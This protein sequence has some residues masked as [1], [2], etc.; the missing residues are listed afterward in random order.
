MMWVGWWR[1]VG[2][3]G[4]YVLGSLH[5]GESVVRGKV[6]EVVGVGEGGLFHFPVRK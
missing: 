6:D 3:E 5:A 2:G 1:R 4:G